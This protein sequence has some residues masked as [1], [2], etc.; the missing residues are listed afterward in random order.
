MRPAEAYVGLGSTEG[1]GVGKMGCGAKPASTGRADR[2]HAPSDRKPADI[3]SNLLAADIASKASKVR[4]DGWTFG[5]VVLDVMDE[6]TPI[7]LAAMSSADKTTLGAEAEQLG[8][9]AGMG[10]GWD[11]EVHMLRIFVVPFV[12][13]R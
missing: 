10:P 12:T 2:R 11:R 4:A 1:T 13:Q 9:E 6:R 3:A 5:K 8:T 7:C